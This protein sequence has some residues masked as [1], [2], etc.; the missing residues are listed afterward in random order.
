MAIIDDIN[1]LLADNTA[2]DISAKDMRD[3]FDIGLGAV[4]HK[5]I[6]T[7]EIQ[8]EIANGFTTILTNTFTNILGTTALADGNEH[9]IQLAMKPGSPLIPDHDP[10]WG[11]ILPHVADNTGQPIRLQSGSLAGTPNGTLKLWVDGGAFVTIKKVNASDMQSDWIVTHVEIQANGGHTAATHIPHM[12]KVDGDYKL[13]IS[14]G[15][16]TWVT[17]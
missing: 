4:K 5:A 11:Y 2:G 17:I 9:I 13:H 1:A 16:A 14:G 3:S 6:S 12:P 7:G 15:V 8:I 10:A